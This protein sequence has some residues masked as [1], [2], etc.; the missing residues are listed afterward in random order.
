MV[1]EIVEQIAADAVK[2]AQKY[3]NTKCRQCQVEFSPK[4][5]NSKFCPQHTT[6]QTEDQRKAEQLRRMNKSRAAA[7]QRKSAE[8]L[9]YNA[10]VEVSKADA[11]ELLGQRIQNRQVRDTC[12]Q[13][14]LK[15]ATETGLYPNR[16]FFAHGYQ[17]TLESQKQRNEVFLVMDQERVIPTEV[18][19]EADVYAIWDYS[20]SWRETDVTFTDFI[21]MR[22]ILKSDWFQLGLMLGIPFEEKPHRAWA[23]FLPQWDPTLQPGYTQKDMRA[24]LTAQKSP[25]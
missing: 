7:K 5:P 16:F 22:R 15:C 25:T 13:L 12:Y 3:R 21:Q 8:S 18:I 14:A 4:T 24:W 19:H 17:K 1:E 20:I 6:V 11:L 23:N 9:K 2:P 10:K